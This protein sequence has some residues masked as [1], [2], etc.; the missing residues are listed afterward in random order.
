MAQ[1]FTVGENFAN[2]TL[3]DVDKSITGENRPSEFGRIDV[4]A[5]L[6]GIGSKDALKAGQQLTFN[7]DSQMGGAE[8]KGLTKAFGPGM[9][10]AQ[11][12]GQ[13]VAQPAIKTLQEGSK[14]LEDRYKGVLESIKGKQKIATDESNIRTAREY[15]ARGLAPHSGGYGVVAD[16]Q[17][18]RAKDL[19]I[20]FGGLE[21]ET[22]LAAEKAQQDIR[23][24]IAQLQYG[25][26]EN[27]L[28]REQALKLA[29]L[30]Q[31]DPNSDLTRKLLEA[32]VA[33]ATGGGSDFS[34]FATL[35]EGQTLFDL[36]S[37]KP[38]YKNAKTSAGGGG[39]GFSESDYE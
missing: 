3:E 13:A 35:G 10:G 38:V 23:S 30:A 34:N 22:G 16:V 21:A 20:Q 29:E 33:K 17:A 24:A 19:G 18:Q 27:A 6:L 28:N 11:A 14:T 15:G 36:L 8:Y 37:G 12:A 9:S 7:D 1:I 2:K 4:L 5:N 26:G 31:K 25:S 39:G 32:Q